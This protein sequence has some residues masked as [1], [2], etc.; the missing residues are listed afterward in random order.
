MSTQGPIVTGSLLLV[1]LGRWALIAGLNSETYPQADSQRQASGPPSPPT[2]V[3]IL[4]S[5]IPECAMR[6][7]RLTRIPEGWHLYLAVPDPTAQTHVSA[8][9]LRVSRQTPGTLVR[10][11][12]A[13]TQCLTTQPCEDMSTRRPSSGCFLKF[14]AM[15][16]N[17]F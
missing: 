10:Q 12:G 11:V 17:I 13:A 3:Q 2:Q 14:H 6:G 5:H 16:S 8:S 7:R 15:H 9:S 4:P 1:L